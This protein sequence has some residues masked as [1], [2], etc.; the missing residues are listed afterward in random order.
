MYLKMNSDIDI[1]YSFSTF[2]TLNSLNH[3]GKH[4]HDF[5]SE[6]LILKQTILAEH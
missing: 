5:K 3:D 6:S 1:T 4:N 2:T